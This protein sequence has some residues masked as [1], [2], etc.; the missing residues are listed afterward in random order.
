ML[1]YFWGSLYLNPNSPGLVFPLAA[2]NH[3]SPHHIEGRN[4]LQC[5]HTVGAGLSGLSQSQRQS[6]GQSL[7][8]H[9]Q[10]FFSAGRVLPRHSPSH[11]VPQGT[12]GWAAPG[13]P[14]LHPRRAQSLL[15][16][17]STW[18]LSTTGHLTHLKPWQY[19]STHSPARPS[20]GQLQG[21]H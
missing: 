21:P 5:Q 6:R 13:P 12:T 7:L 9:T 20:H 15:Q 11:P 1:Q 8:L 4:T 16:S 19:L 3:L 2:K 14:L 10:L 18:Q 17:P